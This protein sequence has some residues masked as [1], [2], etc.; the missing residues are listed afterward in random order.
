MVLTYPPNCKVGIECGHAKTVG[1][2]A[3]IR[4][5][6]DTLKKP[7]KCVVSLLGTSK[8]VRSEAL[9]FYYRFN[10]LSFSE[11]NSLCRFFGV[12]G[13]QCKGHITHVATN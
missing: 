12:L 10:H 8:H 3:K 13:P 5:P 1:G 9:Q 4:L 7:G 11:I 2:S 6:D